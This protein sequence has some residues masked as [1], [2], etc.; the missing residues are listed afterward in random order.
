[1]IGDQ[2]Q[3]GY[4]LKLSSYYHFCYLNFAK[5]ELKIILTNK[6]TDSA[7]A[8]QLPVNFRPKLPIHLH[9]SF[10]FY[11]DGSC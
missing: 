4:Q 9:L 2:I 10:F 6:L 1:M 5:I 3:M 8:N 7:G 11:E